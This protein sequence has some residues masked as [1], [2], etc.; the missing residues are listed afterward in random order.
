M[1]MRF[2][3]PTPDGPSEPAQIPVNAPLDLRLDKE[4][5]R[6]P[7][8]EDKYA[9]QI[10]NPLAPADEKNI[11]IYREAIV[12]QVGPAAPSSV[13]RE[14][15]AQH[16]VDEPQPEDVKFGNKFQ[17]DYAVA[18]NVAYARELSE[19]LVREGKPALGTFVE[20]PSKPP[21]P[22]AEPSA[23][24][25]KME[26]QPPPA[27]APPAPPAPPPLREPLML[28]RLREFRN[29]PKISPLVDKDLA[30]LRTQPDLEK[31]DAR[32]KALEVAQTQMR[33]A[34]HDGD[35][36]LER[37]LR[38]RV[39]ALD[40]FA[41][42]RPLVVAP[43]APAAPVVAPPRPLP[44]PSGEGTDPAKVSTVLPHAF[45]VAPSL[46]SAPA[47]PVV[48][49]AAPRPLPVLSLEPTDP[50]VP[51]S[52]VAQPFIVAPVSV[53]PPTAPQ[54][55]PN[56]TS[57]A[58]RPPVHRRSALGLPPAIEQDEP[59]IQE[60]PSVM[61]PPTE[62]QRSAPLVP[63]TPSLPEQAPIHRRDDLFRPEPEARNE[64]DSLLEQLDTPPGVVEPPTAP[65]AL[66]LADAPT[67]RREP[68]IVEV[69][70]PAIRNRAPPPPPA[71]PSAPDLE[72]DVPTR[73]LIDDRQPD[74][75]T[76]GRFDAHFDVVV[77]DNAL[78]S[79]IRDDLRAFE[80][81]TERAQSG[82]PRSVEMIAEVDA[83]AA[84]F[85]ARPENAV[86]AELVRHYR[87]LTEDEQKP[88][89][90]AN[91]HLADRLAI[92]VLKREAEIRQREL[93]TVVARDLLEQLKASPDLERY[94]YEAEVL[95][96][97]RQK[98]WEEH[99]YTD[100]AFLIAEVL[101]AHETNVE[102]ATVCALMLE[103][104]KTVETGLLLYEIEQ[105]PP[106]YRAAQERATALLEAPAAETDI[107]L[108]RELSAARLDF[109]LA[110]DD[111]KAAAALARAREAALVFD[112]L[113]TR[114]SLETPT[115]P[116]PN[117]A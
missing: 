33:L 87:A 85:R 45:V 57:S 94:R 31:L 56:L 83:R 113:P 66:A 73:D 79:A 60:P 76:Q 39:I 58:E 49:V 54:Q 88:E 4:L 84:S 41:S 86:P 72:L 109:V 89:R 44:A 34:V 104:Q 97:T 40:E 27:P 23:A 30:W 16:R 64:L 67:I 61:E 114:R 10:D 3:E 5:E 62:P 75:D 7:T 13:V 15:W 93:A 42:E 108:M 105:D 24:A 100:K 96:G 21:A 43:A 36:A 51:M 26:P 12:A 82:D 95:M 63:S 38:I 68:A 71:P 111:V 9:A 1:G 8:V 74:L 106:A 52:N 53:E 25:A 35:K 117:R 48:T 28:D 59:T 110:A 55:Q 32:A 65:D 14:A 46:P 78:R 47:V 116:P 11:V 80:R 37:K 101:N 2:S 50:A 70:T 112:V 103:A 22:T 107:A 81:I 90:T 77:R 29:D 69:P 6:M 19:A 20:V 115:K 102:Y 18:R 91:I 92:V 99:P 17:L 98:T